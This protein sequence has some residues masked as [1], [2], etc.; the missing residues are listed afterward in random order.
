MST[1]I[2]IA[3]SYHSPNKVVRGIAPN[4]GKS[5]YKQ[6]RFAMKSLRDFGYGKTESENYM[7]EEVEALVREFLIE[8]EKQGNVKID[9]QFSL[10]VVNVLWQ[11]TTSKQLK[12]GD[13][14][15]K[16]VL[17]LVNEL[18]KEG[19][20][21]FVY[22]FPFL[23]KVLPP[24]SYAPQEMK[25]LDF[26]REEVV[27][28]ESTFDPE[29]EPKNFIEA[30][31]LKMHTK[32]DEDFCREQL[33]CVLADLFSAGSETTSTYL[34]WCL[35]FL[36][37]HTEVQQKCQEEIDRVLGSGM[38]CK[39][40]QAKLTYV[41][42]V[43]QEIF[44]L[45]NVAPSSL[46]HC[47]TEEYH[48]RGFT[49]PKGSLVLSSLQK[50]AMDSKTFPNPTQFRPERFIEHGK[51]KNYPQLS[52]FGVGKRICMGETLAR[53][54]SFIFFTY[55]LQKLNI[56]PAAGKPIPNPKNCTANVTNMAHPFFVQLS[57]RK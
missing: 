43:M 14:G 31:L 52:P 49:I 24:M 47:T 50:F 16:K 7:Q 42:A 1:F 3:R 9:E 2:D 57:K 22:L 4:N 5:W 39:D 44:R 51:L 55:M 37:I 40:D 8:N 48:V 45:A 26:M 27:K 36:A 53:T 56:R 54:T 10:P 41:L 23:T 20:Y 34:K 21:G 25:L 38:P 32:D 6:R 30:Y 11:L 19:F 15:A 35:L 17:D 12:R 18:F 28:H 46:P 33:I 13:D 29:S